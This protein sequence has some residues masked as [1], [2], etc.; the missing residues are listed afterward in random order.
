MT[1]TLPLP[2]QSSALLP[3]NFHARFTL[4]GSVLNQPSLSYSKLVR[5]CKVTRA[6]CVFELRMSQCHSS[7]SPKRRYLVHS[8][9]GLQPIDVSVATS[10][11]IIL[12][13]TRYFINDGS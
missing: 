11:G 7:H 1:P 8:K 13:L 2:W 9:Q 12:H 3:G 10:M 4:P 6:S 5:R